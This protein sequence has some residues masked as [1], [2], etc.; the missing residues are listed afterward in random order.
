MSESS[1]WAH[2]GCR[3]PSTVAVPM[4]YPPERFASGSDAAA[5]HSLTSSNAR[6]VGPSNGQG[7]IMRRRNAE[8]DIPVRRAT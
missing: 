4:M 3:T 6:I 2:R 1:A 5:R 8:T 7:V